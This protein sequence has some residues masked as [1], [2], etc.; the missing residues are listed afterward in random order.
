MSE[1][2]TSSRETQIEET[3]RFASISS[4][5]STTPLSEPNTPLFQSTGA[6]VTDSPATPS[7]GVPPL[8]IA[9]QSLALASGCGDV[10][11]DAAVQVRHSASPIASLGHLKH[12]C[13]ARRTPERRNGTSRSRRTS[14]S[15]WTSWYVQRNSSNAYNHVTAGLKPRR[16]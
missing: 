13:N 6:A 11:S 1:W 10:S 7:E 2:R 16:R 9:H 8:A 15:G 14:R 4:R 12:S 5:Y 3:A